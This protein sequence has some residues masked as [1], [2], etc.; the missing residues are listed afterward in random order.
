MDADLAVR[1]AMSRDTGLRRALA[2]VAVARAE[3]AQADRAPNPM[4]ELALG[5]PIDG[6]SG[7]PAMAAVAQQ[8]TWL[9]TR[10][11]RLD[12][13]DAELK[14]E[15]LDAGWSIVETDA[16]VRRAH[17]AAAIAFDRIAVEEAYAAATRNLERLVAGLV[18]A[19]EASRIDLDRIRVE[20]AE[21]AVAA[22]SSH[23][24]ARRA[25]LV[26]L[27]EIGLP[28][29]SDEFEVSS[30]LEGTTSP[31]PEEELVVD[32]AATARLDVAA[33]GCRVVAA[34]ARVGLADLRRLPEVGAGLAWN[35]TFSQRRGIVP[36][37]QASIPIF[38]DGLPAIAAADA[39][40][41]RVVLAHLE[42]RRRAVANARLA[43]TRL[44]LARDRRVGYEER[45][46]EPAASAERL[47]SSAYAEG[48]VDLT[49]VLLAQQRR[50]QAER[51]VLDQ[52]LAE[53]DAW[54]ELLLGVGGS[55]DLTPM[56]PT[57][58]DHDE[59]VAL[60]QPRSQ[61]IRR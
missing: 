4:V 45:V 54:I 53:A 41:H 11:T 33:A 24:A 38:D 59:R 34:E 49:V 7:G 35:R 29:G 39:G 43:R 18:E 22:E 10:P 46:L 57:I 44:V 20:A 1:V 9:W 37:V 2:D 55:F 13:A 56:V 8:L 3:L 21:A 6:M 12:A 14:S 42:I 28:G 25:R 5:F 60:E 58:P 50:I 51:R 17:A 40:L 27:A 36:G 32:L 15:I 19:G 30:T 48:V 47:A 26:L 52:R 31:I 61:E 16:R 23:I